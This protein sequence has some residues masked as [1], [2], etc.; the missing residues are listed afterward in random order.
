MSDLPRAEPP[1]V[2]E[3]GWPLLLVRFPTLITADTMNTVITAIE[4]A[5]ERRERFAVVVDTSAVSKFPDARTRQILTDWVA[6]ARRTELDQKY[7]V[8]TAVVISSGPLRALTA[9]INLVRRPV[10]PQ[11]WTA[12]LAEGLDWARGKL[13]EAGIP[14]SGRRD[15]NDSIAPSTRKRA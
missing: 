3:R 9:A 12:T 2:D 10:S 7:T 13:L 14:A 8:A 15:G 5:Y 4:R 6:D 1:V 11:H